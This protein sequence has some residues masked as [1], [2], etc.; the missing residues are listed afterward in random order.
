MNVIKYLGVFS[1]LT[2]YTVPAVLGDW[3]KKVFP[4]FGA[5]TFLIFPVHY[6]IMNQSRQMHDSD[7]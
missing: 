3:W 4:I 5:P 1:S 2:D 7:E 6:P